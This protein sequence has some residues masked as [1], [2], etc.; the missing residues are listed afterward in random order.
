MVIDVQAITNPQLNVKPKNSCGQYVNLFMNGYA[1]ANIIDP[2]PSIIVRLLNWIVKSQPI[3]FGLIDNVKCGA[4]VNEW[5]LLFDL[6]VMKSHAFK[7]HR[8][9]VDNN[10][11]RYW[12]QPPF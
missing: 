11:N 6:N 9:S 10:L 8:G 5:L 3:Y 1:K 7:N 4:P 12:I 2:I